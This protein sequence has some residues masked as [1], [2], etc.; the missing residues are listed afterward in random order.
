MESKTVFILILLALTVSGCTTENK[1]VEDIK[2]GKES[3]EEATDS[4]EYTIKYT[5]TGFEPG[6]LVIREGDTITWFDST[7]ENVTVTTEYRS[8][9]PVTEGFSSCKPLEKFSHTFQEKGS[10]TYHAE[11]NL[12]HVATIRVTS[13]N[14]Y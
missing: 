12:D 9:C 11:E 3:L 7:G 6:N 8:E 5:E 14:P 10:Y 13:G 2:E 1:A 4:E